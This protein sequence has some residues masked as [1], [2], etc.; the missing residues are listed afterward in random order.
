MDYNFKIDTQEQKDLQNLKFSFD[1]DM[2]E[3]Q[4]GSSKVRLRPSNLKMEIHVEEE[5]E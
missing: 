3:M 4:I 5:K 2:L 1:G